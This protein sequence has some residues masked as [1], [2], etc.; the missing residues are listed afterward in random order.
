MPTDFFERQE[1]ARQNTTLLRA[2][3]VLAVLAIVALVHL[4][5]SLLVGSVGL[6]DP[7]FLAVSL[8]G[9]TAVV[10]G[11][12][13]R[14]IK[15]M[16]S[17]GGGRLV[18][19][20]G[21]VRVGPNTSD[22]SERRLFNV[23]EEMAIASGTAP[24]GV[25]LLHDEPGINAF[26]AGFTA[27]D[28]VIG[29]T[30]GAVDR[31]SR[32]ELQGVI[33]HEFSHILN[34]DM[35]LNL[36]LIGWLHGIMAIGYLGNAV[37]K[38]SSIPN[39]GQTTESEP[40]EQDLVSKLFLLMFLQARLLLGGGLKLVGA[41]GTFFGN[42]IKAA[43]NREREILADASAVQFTRDPSGLA[44][45]LKKIGGADVG[46]TVS[47]PHAAEASHLLFSTGTSG[48]DAMFATHPPLEERIRRLD[49]GWDGVFLPSVVPVR[50]T[51]SPPSEPSPGQLAN[52]PTPDV[53]VDD[54][55]A[56]RIEDLSLGRRCRLCEPV[57]SLYER[58]D[59]WSRVMAELPR[60]SLLT[61]DA[62]D[63]GF[64]AVTDTRGVRGFVGRRGW[65]VTEA[66][67]GASTQVAG[68][69]AQTQDRPSPVPVVNASVIAEAVTRGGPTAAHLEYATRLI[70]GLPVA[71]INAA[72]DPL[73][74]Q[75]V[76]CALLLHRDAEV[77]LV[78]L[79]RLS[80]CSDARLL[81]ETRRLAEIT[82]RLEVAARLPLTE[83]ALPALRSLTT[84]QQAQLR[85]A[86]G[87][88]IGAD[89]HVSVFEWA[90]QRMLLHDLAEQRDMTGTRHVRHHRLEAVAPQ[91]AVLLSALAH[92]GHTEVAATQRAFSQ[93][94]EV[95]PLPTT[96][97]LPRDEAGL[98]ALDVALTHLERAAGP[99]QR[100]ALYAAALT[101]GADGTATIDEAE[102]LRVMATVLGWPIPLLEVAGEAAALVE[103]SEAVV[104][105]S[106]AALGQP[107][108]LCDRRTVLYESADGWSRVAAEL[109]YGGVVT[110]VDRE[111]QFVKVT[112]PGESAGYIGGRTRVVSD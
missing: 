63:G 5:L 12:A 41:I 75:A 39:R 70:D 88:L 48:L 16:S 111:G 65:V 30:R 43:V 69:E 90:L 105:V 67:E 98:E 83:M 92:L 87:V 49:P 47:H 23:I 54:S 55:Q 14:K 102:L 6:F 26:A 50:A 79:D 7:R 20:L 21:G 3:F 8:V 33:A 13:T 103:Q 34:G 97:L 93:G 27:S 112:T 29:V 101:I 44:G 9:T 18:I 45:A 58:A 80:Q 1:T 66:T 59:G 77:R 95:L 51:V 86:V 11:A 74:A 78:Q 42:L 64:A 96:S 40:V 36:R 38:P 76:A 71:V 68:P 91:C 17:G 22:A 32:Q 108:R 104:P 72:H 89:T 28:A 100:R 84:A 15:E 81:D 2:L 61:L 46:S 60:G 57:T 106:E 19:R 82:D 35:R 110:P 94:W 4:V 85:Q 109:S 37:W 10:L 107:C 31:L 52:V 25:Y 53:V 56:V 24:P 73:G 99:I 62:W